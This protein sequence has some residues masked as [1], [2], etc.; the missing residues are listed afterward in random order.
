MGTGGYD[1]DLAEL[2]HLSRAFRAVGQDARGSVAWKFS[3]AVEPLAEDDPLRHAVEVY[4]RSL[5]G[6]LDR[7]CSGVDDVAS[8]LVETAATYEQLEQTTGVA[9]RAAGLPDE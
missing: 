7:L 2:D 8:A 3:V 9:L 1:V 5:R 6:A 4:Q